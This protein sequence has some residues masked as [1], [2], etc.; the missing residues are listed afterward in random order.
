MSIISPPMGGMLQPPPYPVWKFSVDDYHRLIQSGI[1][2][3]DDPVELLEG[4]IVPKMPRNPPHDTSLK[5]LEKSVESGVPVGWHTRWQSAI[6]LTE[7][8]PEPDGVAVRGDVRDY[9]TRHP[10]PPDIALLMEVADTSLDRDRHLKG[11]LYARAGI[12]IYWIVNL[13]DSQ[14]EVYTDPTGPDPSPCYRQRQD[15]DRNAD[16]PL[17]IGGQ[18]VGLVAVRDLLP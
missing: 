13:V 8:E 18:Q 11:S 16:V 2:T 17:M 6:T 9:R 14:V 10:G 12:P 15:Y 7:S 3:E 1:L 5:L 4:W